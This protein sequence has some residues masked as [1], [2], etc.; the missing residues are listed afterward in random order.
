MWTISVEN[1]NIW[2]R[3]VLKAY[4]YYFIIIY[5][6]AC[7]LFFIDKQTTEKMLFHDNRINIVV[8]RKMILV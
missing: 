5:L 4:C 2:K 7:S 8:T 6:L 1:R 3:I